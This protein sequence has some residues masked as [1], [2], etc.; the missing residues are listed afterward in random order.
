MDGS[1]K[2]DIW[3]TIF[4]YRLRTFHVLSI[5]HKIISSNQHPLPLGDQRDPCQL[6]PLLH[7]HL[8][9][10]WQHGVVRQL[11]LP[12]DTA[13]PRGEVSPGATEGGVLPIGLLEARI[14]R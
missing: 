13:G 2:Y 8:Q 1:K 7:H 4:T 6:R 9:R 10:A 5:L 11:P 3:L 12:A 14:L